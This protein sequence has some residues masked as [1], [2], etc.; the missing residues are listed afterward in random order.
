MYR[1]NYEDLTEMLAITADA[2][3]LG[4]I[5][6]LKYDHQQ[7]TVTQLRVSV[8]KGMEK[9]LAI[10]RGRSVLIPVGSV[11][12]SSDVVLLGCDLYCVK[13]VVV[14]DSDN[15]A[16]LSTFI[17]KNV[18][19]S[20]NLSVGDVES[21]S[22]DLEDEWRITNLKVR[23]EKAMAEPLGLKKGLLGKAPLIA[24]KT[25]NINLVGDMAFLSKSLEELKKDVSVYD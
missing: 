21:L 9:E 11:S 24:V 12:K 17:G 5:S 1:R 25:D 14:P 22:V 3:I 7:W 4:T 18:V 2:R 20:E 16:R 23:V 13:D 6:D 10:G 8:N 15:I 19:T